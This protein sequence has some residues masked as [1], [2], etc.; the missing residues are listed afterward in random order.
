MDDTFADILYG[1]IE[2]RNQFFS[3]TINQMRPPTR[4]AIMTRFMMNEMCLLEL[5]NR[6]H[7]NSMRSAQAAAS[8]VLN[9]P[10][11]FLDSVQVTATPTQIE[12]ATETLTSP[13]PETQCAIC[14]DNIVSDATRIRTCG[15]TYHRNCLT[16]WLTMS[17][18]CPVCRHDIR[19]GHP[20]AQTLPA[21][22]GTSLPPA[23]P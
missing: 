20:P 23:A 19:T 16:N 4:D 13:P 9:L 5:T 14:Q 17:V 3:R 6:V 10:A 2:G 15:H 1:I 22:S 11:N 7:Q 18:R 21:S 12:H 8:L